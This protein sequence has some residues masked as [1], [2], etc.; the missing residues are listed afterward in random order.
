MNS[1]SIKSKLYSLI[2]LVAGVLILAVVIAIWSANTLGMITAIARFE[3]TH[4]VARNRAMTNLLKY[5]YLGE[6]QYLDKYYESIKITQSYNGVFGQ[7]LELDRTK[8]DTEFAK[9]VEDTFAEADH[10]MSEIIVN[11][12]GLL[13]WHPLIKQLVKIAAD[14]HVEGAKYEGLVESLTKT[15]DIEAKKKIFND[16]NVIDAFFVDSEIKF[17]KGCGDLA[18]LVSSIVNT[19]LVVIFLLSIALVSIIA[20]MITRSI[21]DPL[22]RLISYSRKVAGGDLKAVLENVKGKEMVQLQ[23]AIRGM[24][25]NLKGMIGDVVTGVKKLSGSAEELELVSE[26]MET[27][28][29][30][31]AKKSS[32]ASSDSKEL[33][34]SMDKASSLVGETAAD[35][36]D[37]STVVQEMTATINDIAKNTESAR[38]TTNQA[39]SV[40]RSASDKINI[41]NASAMTI[42]KVTETITEI[43]E[44]TNLLALNATIE[45]ARAGEAGKGFAVVAGEIKE[46]A[47]QT[48]KATQGIKKEIDGIQS[49]TSETVGQIENVF[50]VIEKVESFVTAIASSIEEQAVASNDIAKNIGKIS[51]VTQEV[52]RNVMTS[53]NDARRISTDMT[54]IEAAAGDMSDNSTQVKASAMTIA[55]LSTHLRSLTEKFR[56]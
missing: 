20:L 7:L 47:S 34:Q 5:S 42:S 43:S 26:K 13:Y 3:R 23:D 52:S 21:T 45:A 54:N 51:G 50:K 41:L 30:N 49:A 35:L 24:V 12:V 31:T 17:S 22:D 46:L 56:I 4:T 28:S 48:A 16:I 40:A 33:C 15:E 8:T 18:S 2:A 44:Q 9:I 11:R 37:I 38:E 55:E 53:S 32:G 10:S 29:R 39:V 6:R 19:L 14:V 1:G 36:N 25:E 27:G